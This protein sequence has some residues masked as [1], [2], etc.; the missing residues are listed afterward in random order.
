MTAIKPSIK[1][2]FKDLL[3]EIKSFKYKLTVKALS[4]KYKENGDIEFTPVY[5]NST[6]KII[7][8]AKYDFDKS[9]QKILYRIDNWI[10]EGSGWVI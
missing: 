2:L 8:N 4:N 7:I 1:D 3:E 5:F 6:T 10:N 9:Y